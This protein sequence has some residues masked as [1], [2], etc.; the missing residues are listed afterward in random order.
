MLENKSVTF[1]FSVSV[2]DTD[3]NTVIATSPVGDMPWGVVI[4]D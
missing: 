1:F 2:I 3:S 4:D